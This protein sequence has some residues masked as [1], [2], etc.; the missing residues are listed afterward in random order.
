MRIV[1]GRVPSLVI[2][3]IGI[4]VTSPT[5][6]LTALAIKVESPNSPLFLVQDCLDRRGRHFGLVKF[7]T[8]DNRGRI[9]S[10]G[11]VLR[12][13]HLDELPQLWNVMLETMH[14]DVRLFGP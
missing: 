4:V 11:R 1:F 10:V 6:C 8:M 3:A 5:F 7:R 9:T 13:F 12:R 2:A 14:L